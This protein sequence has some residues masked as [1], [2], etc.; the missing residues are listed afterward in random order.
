MKYLTLLLM[1]MGVAAA[2]EFEVASIRPAIDDGNH[3]SD[4]DGG[5]YKIHNL[6]LK[7]LIANGWQVD[8][9]TISGGPSWADSDGFD[10]NARIPREPGAAKEDAL[11]EMTRNLLI[12]RFHL[13]IHREPRQMAGY[14]LRVVKKGSKMEPARPEQ[15]G[16]ESHSNGSHLGATNYT[17]EALA[18]RLSRNPDVAKLVVDKTGLK[19]GFNFALDWTPQQLES[20][21]AGTPDEHPSIFGALEEQLGLKLESA[22]VTIQAIVIDRATKPEFDQ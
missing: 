20:S 16:S 11:R 3:D 12:D 18:R 6:T 5:F 7:R 9:G 13:A 1:I 2:Q 10:I 22:K 15:D 14:E 4:S 19:G 21:R 17:M 8:A